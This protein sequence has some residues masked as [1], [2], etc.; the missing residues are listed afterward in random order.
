MSSWSQPIPVN[1][2]GATSPTTSGYGAGYIFG[3]AANACG[4]GQPDFPM[5]NQADGCVLRYQQN[6]KVLHI[7][8][9]DNGLIAGQG[10]TTGFTGT[11]IIGACVMTIT[12]GII[13]NV[14]G[15]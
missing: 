3:W 4:T 10:F 13:T 9:T 6:T 5:T 7:G 14:T 11:K 2:P 12:K 8:P 1:V 15:C